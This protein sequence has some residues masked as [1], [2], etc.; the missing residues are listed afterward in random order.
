[1]MTYFAC[2]FGL[3][4]LLCGFFGDQNA[5]ALK[6]STGIYIGGLFFWIGGLYEEINGLKGRLNKL[7]KNSDKE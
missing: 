1:M 4:F 7:E 6:C 3:L 5:F 2:F